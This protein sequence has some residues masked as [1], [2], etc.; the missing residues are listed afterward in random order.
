MEKI[1]DGMLYTFGSTIIIVPIFYFSSMQLMKYKKEIVASSMDQFTN[2]IFGNI[3][4]PPVTAQTTITNIS[5]PPMYA[6]K[7][8]E[9][10]SEI[11][12]FFLKK[13]GIN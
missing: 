4:R 13:R 7:K 5:P 1:I 10:I 2:N 6:K 8:E 3:F 11:T 12:S 9:P